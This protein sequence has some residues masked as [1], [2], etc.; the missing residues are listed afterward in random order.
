MRNIFQFLSVDE[1]FKL[2]SNKIHNKSG[3]PRNLFLHNFLR[4]SNL[5]KNI[6]RPF[7][8]MRLRG[9]MF[10]ILSSINYDFQNKPKI[11]DETS[12]YLKTLFEVDCLKLQ[13]LIRKDLSNW[14][15]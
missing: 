10:S 14:L 4:K 15:K 8:P 2:E 9:A 3:L 12:E 7:T 13:D 11:N 6:T 1:S 5:L